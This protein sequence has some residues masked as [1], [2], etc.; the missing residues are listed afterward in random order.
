[1][2]MMMVVTRHHRHPHRHVRV[3]VYQ[4]TRVGVLGRLNVLVRTASEY[5]GLR[6]VQ[7]SSLGLRLSGFRVLGQ[8]VKGYLRVLWYQGLGCGM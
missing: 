6:A 5:E 4:S 7:Y 2:V 8:G 3:F 1:M